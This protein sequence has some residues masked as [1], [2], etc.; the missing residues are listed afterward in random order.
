MRKNLDNKTRRTI[1]ITGGL[2]G[3]SS[4]SYRWLNSACQIMVLGKTSC[5]CNQKYILKEF[6]IYNFLV[7]FNSNFLLTFSVLLWAAFTILISY[8]FCKLILHFVIILYV[9]F[10]FK[11]WFFANT[12]QKIRNGLK[13]INER[14]CD[15]HKFFFFSI[16]KLIFH[17]I[18]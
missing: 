1:P 2:P 15:I 10:V 4:N 14:E 11:I 8:V 17:L 6:C 9:R 3:W 5:K 18:I 16:A 12:F 7:F 13:H